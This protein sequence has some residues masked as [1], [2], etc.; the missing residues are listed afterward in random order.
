MTGNCLAFVL[1]G[2]G[3]RG[4]LQVGA[5]KAIHEAGLRPDL[6][7]GT[8]AG[9]V[10]AAFLSLRGFNIQ[11]LEDLVESWR[12]ASD[13]N[14]LPSN[15]L[16]LTTRALFGRTPLYS[17]HRMREF[18]VA[19]GLKPELKFGDLHDVRLILVATDLNSGRS[20]LYGLR[21]EDNILD[22]VLA[23]TAI[24]PWVTPIEMNGQLVIDGGMVS[25]LPIEPALKAGA[26]EI[27]ALDLIDSR[28]ITAEEH[29]VGTLLGKVI[30]TIEKRQVDLEL[31]LAAAQS[32]PVAH[33][34]LLGTECVSLWNFSHTD[35]LIDMGYL[36]A[37]QELER[38]SNYE[39]IQESRSR[40]LHAQVCG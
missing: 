31:A 38:Q 36:I 6:L 37:C 34:H 24:P 16:W 8:S 7:V 4:A 39:W 11:S 26:T 5:L 23:S 10:N 12:A 33:L 9:A 14:L 1:G 2:G 20:I 22:G 21:P 15:I 18:F 17:T 30:Y 19:N 29:G 13:A 25:N 35:D 27:V 32:V 3:A 28:E 40:K